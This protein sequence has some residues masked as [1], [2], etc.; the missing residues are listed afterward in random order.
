MTAQNTPPALSRRERPAKPALTREGIIEAAVA[1]LES[2]GLGKVTMRRIAA[3]L[4]TGPASLYVYVRNTEDLHAQILDALLGRM[5]PVG[6]AGTWRDR[7]HAQLAA[8]ATVLFEHPE[9]ARMTMSTHPVGP[10]YFSLVESVL[11]L[12]SEGGV[13]DAGAAW[14]VDLLLASVTA[15]AVEHGGEQSA[16]QQSEALSSLAASIAVAPEQSYPRIVRLGDDMLSGTGVAR[17]SW[18]LDVLINGILATPRRPAAAEPADP[19]KSTK[20]QF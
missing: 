19:A 3:A 12:L 14:G 1:I 13:T 11:D 18:G 5:D 20:E 16:D 17:F 6:T 9:I 8:Y 15:T 4:D 10:H 7:L 2:D